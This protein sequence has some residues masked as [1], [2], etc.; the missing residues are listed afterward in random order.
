ML[1]LGVATR[2]GAP[3]LPSLRL[4]DYLHRKAFDLAA[5]AVAAAQIW[6]PWVRVSRETF[7]AAREAQAREQQAEALKSAIVDHALAAIVSTDA[8]G[9]IVEFNPAAEACSGARA[10]RCSAAGGGRSCP[11]PARAEQREAAHAR[12]RARR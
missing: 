10:R 4:V 1:F 8:E 6:A 3:A 9:R 11:R 2:C 12:R 5:G 7:G